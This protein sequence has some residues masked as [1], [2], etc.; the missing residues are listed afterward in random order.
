MKHGVRA[1]KHLPIYPDYQQWG[2]AENGNIWIN[3]MPFKIQQLNN[4]L[5]NLRIDLNDYILNFANSVSYYQAECN[6]DSAVILLRFERKDGSNQGF[7]GEHISIIFDVK[8]HCLLGFTRMQAD[9]GGEISLSHQKILQTAIKFLKI[10]ASDL[11]NRD[12]TIPE[13]NEI[14]P[15]DRMIFEPEL[16]IDNTEIQWIDEHSEFILVN[17]LNVEISGMKVKM[18]LPEKKLWAWVI[19]DKNGQI[20]TFER[21]I[22]WDFEKMQRKTEM[23]LHDKWLISQGIKLTKFCAT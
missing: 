21:N 14:K 4:I 2:L 11:I 12:I 19:V 22:S 15:S 6:A 9:L 16:C 23:W 18:F 3:D 7:N 1:D 5:S 17:N 20:E 8:K 13:L 10:H